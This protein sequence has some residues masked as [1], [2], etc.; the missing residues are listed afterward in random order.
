MTLCAV[1]T[2]TSQRMK[3]KEH[4][5]NIFKKNKISIC[6]Y[7]SISLYKMQKKSESLLSVAC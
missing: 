5:K 7:I 6:Y 3:L 1:N 4:N 2:Y